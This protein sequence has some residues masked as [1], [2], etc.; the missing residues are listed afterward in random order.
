MGGVRRFPSRDH[1]AAGNGTAP[2]PVISGRSDRHRLNRGGNRRINRALHVVARTQATWHPLAKAYV[3]KKRAAG[4]T[5]LIRCLKRH[6]S[7]VVYRTMLEGLRRQ[8]EA[9]V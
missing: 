5:R 6:L 3:E 9:A 7:D 1:F 4:K 8:E 2:I